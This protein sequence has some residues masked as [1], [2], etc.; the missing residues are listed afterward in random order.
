MPKTRHSVSR[1]RFIKY[2]GASAGAAAIAGCNTDDANDDNSTGPNT[3]GE[4]GA[5]TLR[6]GFLGPLV[7]EEH[8][9]GLSITKAG[10]MAIR[11]L[12]DIAGAD[13]EMVTGDTEI[14]SG[15][16]K[17]EHQRLALEENVDVT[18][19]PFL[20]SSAVGM[21]ESVADQQL[22]NFAVGPTGT[23][24]LEPIADNYDRYKYWFAPGPIN[25][26]ELAVNVNNFINTYG[27]E[28]W[29]SC[30]IYTEDYFNYE[31]FDEVLERGDAVTGLD[32]AFYDKVATGTQD[33]T[34]IWDRVENAGVDV[35]FMFDAFVGAEAAMQWNNQKRPFEYGGV[36]VAAQ[37]GTFWE[38]LDGAGEYVF[39]I[40][41]LE[42]DIEI[43]GETQPFLEGFQ[44]RYGFFP[45]FY[46]GI[47]YDA[48]MMYAQAVEAVGST[49]E[50][51]LI[52]YLRDEA[53]LE[54]AVSAPKIEFHERGVEPPDYPHH[55]NWQ[56]MEEMGIPI[57]IQWQEAAQGGGKR[58]T[59]AP[60]NQ[61]Y[62]EYQRPD[63]I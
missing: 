30:A 32:V 39:S 47:T 19:G 18:F 24:L 59:F 53:I 11:D 42:P 27:S 3:T 60:E 5:D 61:A 52:P 29:D 4:I 22:L 45:M 1:R 17:E 49:D 7:N 2:S 46:A 20:S 13:I 12:G 23:N 56:G 63:W 26:H 10:E 33:F 50:E 43:A 25:V 55:F 21:I 41:N 57:W 62:A 58:V 16:A 28:L 48:V 34:P 8:P 15:K 31:I 9:W 36:N 14:S 35:C 54:P 6:L 37:L 51:D 38:E 44:K 40:A